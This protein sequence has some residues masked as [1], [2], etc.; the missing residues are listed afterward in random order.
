MLYESARRS[1]ITRIKEKVTDFLTVRGTSNAQAIGRQGWEYPACFI[2]GAGDRPLMGKVDV[3]MGGVPKA[4]IDRYITVIVTEWEMDDE[5]ASED[6]SLRLHLLTQEALCAEIWLPE[7][8]PIA[9]EGSEIQQELSRNLL[10][11]TGFYS[12]VRYFNI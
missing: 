7:L 4:I 9:Y 8:S 1:F 3:Q 5:G 6:E 2:M 11:R 12:I 10:F